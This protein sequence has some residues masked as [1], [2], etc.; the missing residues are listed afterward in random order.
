MAPEDRAPPNRPD[1]Q[2]AAGGGRAGM[3]GVTTYAE[4][5]ER[6]LDNGYEPLPIEPGTKRP[7]P[8]QWSK[9]PIDA[10]QVTSWKLQYP[11]HGI[12]VRTGRAVA[13]DIDVE[14][15]DI[16][17]A[18]GQLV[19]HRLGQTLL[20]VG[21]WP[22]RLFV[23]RAE[24]PFRGFGIYKCD[25]LALGQQ[26]VAFG[27]HP[28][29]G[30]PYSWPEESVLDVPLEDLP[31]VTEQQCR[32]LLADLA[33]LLPPGP[34]SQG[35]GRRRADGQKQKAG[36][37]WDAEGRVIDGRDGHLSRIA[38]HVLHDALDAGAP[39]DVGALEEEAWRRFI[40]STDLT[41]T[42]K[43]G[44]VP[45]GPGDAAD[46]IRNK[47]QLLREGNLPWR[48]EEPVEPPEDRDRLPVDL[49]R[50]LLEAEITK[51]CARIHDWH[52]LPSEDAAP[53]IGIRAT[54]GLGK[55]AIARRELLR[56]RQRLG[57]VAGAP[58]R[59]VVCT[60]T[61]ALAEE[62]AAALRADGGSVAVLRGY[63]LNHPVL[64][65][66]MCRDLD[67]VQAALSMGES[68][69]TRAC[70]D[71]AGRR[72]RH[73]DGCL[74]QLNRNEVAGAEIIVAPYDALYSGFP[75]RPQ[76]IALILVDEGCWGRAIET[77]EML[78]VE[79]F[80]HELLSGEDAEPA[81]LRRRAATAFAAVGE[82]P[83]TRRSL[84]TAGLTPADID[85]AIALEGERQRDPG[86]VP[87]MSSV[88]RRNALAQV[89]VNTRTDA[90]IAVWRAAGRLL[91]ADADADGRIAIEPAR[92]DGQRP[93][94]LQWAQSIHLNLRDRPILH[95]D[96]TLQP[97]LARRILPR[98][99]VVEIEADAAH[100]SLRLVTGRFGKR[101]LC[102]GTGEA[103]DESRRRANRLEEVVT[104]VRWHARRHA[105]SRTLVI[106][107][108][109][110]EGAF[111]SIP[112]VETAHFN[113]VAGLDVF[114]DVGL[115]VVVGRPLPPEREIA[116]LC[117]AWF[118]IVPTGG[119]T[120][121][122][123]GVRLRDGSIR[124]VR[125]HAHE[126]P[127]AEL[128]RAAICN[129]ELL[130]A[131]GRGRGVNRTA[132]DPLEVHLLADVAVPMLHDRVS[133]WEME[134]PTVLLRMLLAGIAVDSPTDAVA[135]HPDLFNS[136][137]QAR[138]A[139]DRSGFGGH[140]PHRDPLWDLSAKSAAYRR[141]GR[142]CSW[143]RA[144]W[145]DGDSDAARLAL[146]AAL[147]PL[148]EWR[149]D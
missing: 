104:Y 124:P 95:L 42:R 135:L 51:A 10:A 28:D 140:F 46:K 146:E 93:I 75:I 132:A 97:D 141:P 125:M 111:A 67:V 68:V 131:I 110:C 53:Q 127:N 2:E 29:I 82:G 134:K 13:V 113:A 22:K 58:Y 72:C 77:T 88:E 144:Y 20:R 112:G 109:S 83:V 33:Q 76:E 63:K 31:L 86:L 92:A 100:A 126:A 65:K 70:A 115:L 64:K 108:E 39:L 116:R 89:A 66:P 118:G 129:D 21:R 71:K 78:R 117:G 1:D 149:P 90:F 69:Q 147:G 52:V 4:S 99:E 123:R 87:G 136:A 41:R 119:Y 50:E 8:L 94:R 101:R 73:I 107:Y 57:Q 9:R 105:P 60:S 17:H 133:N 84:R 62:T 106:T 19:Q 5:A 18:A 43:D 79:S 44:V 6:L 11:G 24:T 59:I 27:I 142:G 103:D 145:L 23:Y 138:K 36:P 16:A 98:L 143:R 26:F 45:Y 56:L 55:S 3:R 102:P 61:H 38:Y 128:L 81:A 48:R 130:Q 14:E 37:N 120:Q 35:G 47:F 122:R 85:R 139:F 114:R 121:V 137:E 25:L 91:T 80:G 12:G 32:D 30:S 74:K 15:S 54:V 148:A 96:A 40:E 7:S 49:A 34:S